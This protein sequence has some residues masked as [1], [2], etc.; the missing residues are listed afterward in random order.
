MVVGVVVRLLSVRGVVTVRS[1]V[2]GVV[3][4]L[5]V[6]SVAFSCCVFRVRSGVVVRGV[7]R[8]VVRL[9]TSRVEGVRVTSFGLSL[10]LLRAS[11]FAR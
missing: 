6:R 1:V 9:S 4:V 2:R 10:K 7:S 11:I 5:R 3:V 8:V